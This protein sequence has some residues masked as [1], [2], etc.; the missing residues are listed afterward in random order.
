MSD[1]NNDK[2]LEKTQDQLLALIRDLMRELHPEIAQNVKLGLNSALD[3]DL[4]FDSLSRVELMLRIERAFAVELPERLLAEAETPRDLLREILGADVITDQAN[5]LAQ[6]A[7]GITAITGLPD[8]AE[9]LL[10]MLDWHHK[11]HPDRTHILLYGDKKEATAIS[12]A[13]LHNGATQIAAGLQDLGLLP[14]RTVAIMLPTSHDYLYSF[15]GI[16]L[17]GGIPVPIYPPVRLSQLEDHLRR[18]AK[19]LGNAQAL[20]LI[21]VPEARSVARLLKAQVDD[22]QAIVT[23][24]ELTLS[25]ESFKPVQIHPHDLAFLQYTSGS[26]GQPKGVMLTHADL[27][28]NIRAM[29]QAV[30]A[31]S[32]DI[33]V[34]WLPLYHDMGLIGAWLGSLYYAMPLVLMSPLTFLAHPG[35]WLWTIHQHQATLSAAPNFAYELCLNKIL[36]S[37]LEGLDLSSWRLAFNGAE[38]V[39]PNTIRRFRDRFSLYGFG[40]KTLT[41][42]YGLAEAA[43]G[44][45]FPP[46]GRGMIIDRIQRQALLTDGQAIPAAADDPLALENVAC[47]QPLRGYQIRIV[48]ASGLELP[49]RRE[50]HIQ[51]TGPS[52]TQ[53]YYRNPEASEELFHDGWLDT[54]DLGY[55]AA[56]DL[57][58][59]SRTKDLIIRAGRNIYPYEL[60]EAVGNIPGI[61][62]GCVAVFGSVDSVNGTERLIVVAESREPG[63]AHADLKEKIRSIANNLQEMPPDEI[64][65][66]PPQTVLKTSSGKIRRSAIRELFE[67]GEIGHKSRA[68]WLQFLRLTLAAIRPQWRQL[69]RK[70]SETLYALYCKFIFWLLVCPV[71]LLAVLLPGRRWRWKLVRYASRLLFRL[72]GIPISVTG[73]EHLI[74]QASV[75]IAN[76]SSYTDGLVLVATLPDAPILVA[77]GELQKKFFARLIL[78]KLGVIFVERFEHQQSV[79]DAKMTV[80]QLKKGQAI[81]TFP[82]GTLTRAPG[83][84]PFHMG[85]FCAASEAGVPIVPVVITGTRSILRSDS[86]FPHKGAVNVQICKLLYPQATDWPA[87]VALRDEARQIMLKKLDEPDLSTERPSF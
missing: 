10:Q 16:L 84:L 4:G 50:G 74:D 64:I 83:L 85:P 9:T 55:I 36:D 19:I 37:D 13:D 54:G 34:S 86:W 80:D 61:R 40:E 79:I 73:Q 62:K 32:S 71:W 33:F 20:F 45:A 28:A 47:G 27:L 48:D 3:R 7:A 75:I 60:E 12:Y 41:P 66:S 69:R 22:L 42:V 78:Q 70:I 5:V 76:H 63:A 49:E 24:E 2:L 68:V 46:V 81:V 29:G 8:E 57:Y 59:T 53:G 58:I 56:A 87:A 1:L 26:T 6:P 21:T 77:K 44:L 51:F 17:A 25:V 35:R 18:H 31:K 11:A 23:P 43:V 38:P 67:K 52:A 82:E 15:F 39:S 30:K 72:L 65:I 14:G